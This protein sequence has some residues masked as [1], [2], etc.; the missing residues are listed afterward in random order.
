M[1]S[2][3][4]YSQEE[5]DAALGQPDLIAVCSG[6]GRVR[7]QRATASSGRRTR[8]A[9]WSASGR[10]VEAGGSATVVARDARSDRELGDGGG[11]GLGGRDAGNKV[12]CRAATVRA[13]ASR[14][15][16]VQAGDERASTRFAPAA[17]RAGD[18]CRVRAL[19]SA[20]VNLKADAR[21]WVWGMAAAQASERATVTAWGSANVHAT[22]SVTVEALET[23]V[24]TASGT[25]TVRAF[26]SVMVRAR[27]RSRVETM[28]GAAV[29]RHG[30]AAV[31]S[32]PTVTVATRPTT[33]EER[34]AWYGV[35][36]EDGVA[37]LYKAVDESFDSYH[38]RSYDPGTEPTAEDWDEG[39]REC[40]AGLHFSPGRRSRLRRRR[41]KC[42]SWRA[43]C[44]S[45]TSRPPRRPLS[46]QGQGRGVCAPVYE[47]DEDGTPNPRRAS[48]SRTAGA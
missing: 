31:V 41:T 26:G 36:V 12:S 32:G 11:I 10:L 18:R 6:D 47:V 27:G 14:H 5:L 3:D 4:V 38:G 19:L 15:A 1:K 39:E 21:A 23:A 43:P 45:R 40:G 35:P 17:V 33:A 2:I 8:P 29:M 13:V 9:W 28:G 20:R 24:V 37:I 42:D 46:G 30:P 16:I 22:D 34:C 25:V 48:A 7:G 44:G